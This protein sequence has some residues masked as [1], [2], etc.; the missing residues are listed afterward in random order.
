MLDLFSNL[1]GTVNLGYITRKQKI[2]RIDGYR[3][4]MSTE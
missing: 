3:V 4:G 2:A 1:F